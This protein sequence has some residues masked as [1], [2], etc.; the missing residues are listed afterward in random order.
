MQYLTEQSEISI[1]AVLDEHNGKEG[2]KICDKA[3]KD[4]QK[5]RYSLPPR[6]GYIGLLIGRG[7][8]L[9][10]LTGIAFFASR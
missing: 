1:L 4:A 9:K 6:K 8:A 7:C 2:K 10:R 5:L 3:A